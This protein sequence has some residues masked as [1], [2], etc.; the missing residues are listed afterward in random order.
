[1]YYVLLLTAVLMIGMELFTSLTNQTTFYND[2]AGAIWNR[3]YRW[4]WLVGVPFAFVPTMLSYSVGGGESGT[5]E[6]IGFPL[7][8]AAVDEAGL[9]YVG[10]M[11]IPFL[12]ANA[13]IWFFVPHILLYIWSLAIKVAN[14]G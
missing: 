1:M 2:T 4:R 6:I 8:I 11:S 3:I 5:Y 10:R 14:R 9:N 12:A 13:A 7:A